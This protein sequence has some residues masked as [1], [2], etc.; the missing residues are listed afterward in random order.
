MR[1]SLRTDVAEKKNVVRRERML[2]KW[3]HQRGSFCKTVYSHGVFHAKV[4]QQI[5]I[6]GHVRYSRITVYNKI[7]SR[8]WKPEPKF[9]DNLFFIPS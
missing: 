5:F 2:K 8:G 3:K 4:T 1:V 9:V 6:T 7:T